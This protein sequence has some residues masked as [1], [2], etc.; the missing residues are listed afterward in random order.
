MS[1]HLSIITGV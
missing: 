1:E